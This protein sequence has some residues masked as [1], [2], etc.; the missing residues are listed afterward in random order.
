MPASRARPRS[1]R[2]PRPRKALEQGA[3]CIGVMEYRSNA[4]P[5]NGAVE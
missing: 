1:R 5:R 4:A 3:R 2:R